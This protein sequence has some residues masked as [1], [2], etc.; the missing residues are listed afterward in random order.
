MIRQHSRLGINFANYFDMYAQMRDAGASS[1]RVTFVMDAIERSRDQFDFRAYD[2]L[3]FNLAAPRNM[4]V[5]GVLVSG[6]ANWAHDATKPKSDFGWSVPAGL[7]F[8]W[9]DSRN[10]WGQFVYRVVTRYKANVRAWEIWNEPNLDGFWKAD[11]KTYAQLMRVSY[12][13]IKAADPTAIVVFGGLYQDV[14]SDRIQAFWQALRELPDAAANHF[15][16]DAQGFHLY[17]GGI[18]NSFDVIESMKR[19]QATYNLGVHDWWI[20]ESGIRVYDEPHLD[21]VTPN[22]QASFVI[23]SMSYALYKDVKQFYYWRTNDADDLIQPWGLITNN[24]VKRPAY[25]AYRVAATYLPESFNGSTRFWDNNGKVSRIVFDGTPQGRVTVLWNV[26]NQPQKLTLPVDPNG[27][28][29]IYQ[30]GSSKNIATRQGSIEIELPPS[31]N[32]RRSENSS[33]CLAG[34]APQIVIESQAQ[35]TMVTAAPLSSSLSLLPAYATT[36]RVTLSI[37]TNSPNVTSYDLQYRLN[38]GNWITYD[39]Y[40]TQFQFSINLPLQGLI[41]FRARV[42]DRAGNVQD[43]STANI[44]STMAT[45]SNTPSAP[46]GLPTFTPAPFTQPPRKSIPTRLFLPVIIN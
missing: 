21:F 6:G 36:G 45:Y 38:G 44:V 46:T 37:N 29:V 25:N 17:D 33:V 3:V 10:V 32:F 41:E 23:Q 31:T 14:N 39:T 16:F 20:T 34:G 26:S 35:S 2:N 22:E 24:G 11:A 5:L 43:W 7:D 42:R 27:A 40:M 1:D 13:A 4:K 18:C 19:M 8:A 9:N 28:T 30:N 15:Y 12:Q